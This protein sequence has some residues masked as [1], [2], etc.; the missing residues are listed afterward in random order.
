MKIILLTVF[1]FMITSAYAQ[2]QA[3]VNGFNPVKEWRTEAAAGIFRSFKDSTPL[4]GAGAC[5]GPMFEYRQ[6]NRWLGDFISFCGYGI[7]DIR[8]DED[9]DEASS[10]ATA[11]V[12]LFNAVGVRGSVSY[13]PFGNNLFWSIMISPMGTIDQFM[14]K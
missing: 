9:K 4:V 8:S 2:E 1:M 12:Q 5:Y 6:W 10:I 7:G 3:P 13:D 14:K 11:G